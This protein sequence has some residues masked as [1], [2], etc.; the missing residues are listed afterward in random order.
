MTTLEVPTHLNEY[1]LQYLQNLV[2]RRGNRLDP[3]N[4]YQRIVAAALLE[5][6]TTNYAQ[7]SVPAVAK[8][9]GV[10]TATV[11]RI[12]PDHYALYKAGHQLGLELYLEWLSADCT[13]PNPLMRL[14]ILSDRRVQVWTRPLAME[15]CSPTY[16]M[17]CER[18]PSLDDHSK[19]Y[20]DHFANFWISQFR[21][22]KTEGYLDLEPDWHLVEMFWGPIECLV[23]YTTVLTDRPY[24]S[25]TSKFEDCWRAVDDFLTLYGTPYFHTLRKKLSWDKALSAYQTSNSL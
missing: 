3:S 8:R 4:R 22:L 19:P 9:A 12:F 11:Y 16:F 13:H 20:V 2:A 23:F 6:F 14:A 17:I 5:I 24:V 25:E 21:R 10:S 1:I 15:A 18:D 7:L